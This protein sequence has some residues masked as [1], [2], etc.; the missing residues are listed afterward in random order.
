M[1]KG[2][3][4]AGELLRGLAL[5]DQKFSIVGADTMLSS[6][7]VRFTFLAT[8]HHFHG[9]IAA[10]L[11]AAQSDLQP[12]L[13]CL[14][15]LR[16][17]LSAAI[18]LEMKR[19][20]TAF[21]KQLSRVMTIK[22]SGGG[23]EGGEGEEGK[24]RSEVWY[25][26]MELAC[27]RG[28]AEIAVQQVHLL[29]IDLRA[30]MHDSKKRRE[31]K[32]VACRIQ[33]G[34]SL[35]DDANR[36]F[37]REG[38]L[39]KYS[40]YKLKARYRFFLFNDKLV[41]SH[42]SQSGMYKIHNE[43]LLSMMRVADVESKK[44]LKF[45]LIHPQKTFIVGCPNAALKRSWMEDIGMSVDECVERKLRMEEVRLEGRDSPGKG[46]GGE[47]N[48]D[49]SEI[50]VLEKGIEVDEEG[51]GVEVSGVEIQIG[52]LEEGEGEG[53]EEESLDSLFHRALVFSTDLLSDT[54]DKGHASGLKLELYSLFKQ[55]KEGDCGS[56]KDGAALDELGAMKMNAW[57]KRRGVGKQDA[58]S[59]Y[60][61]LLN[62]ISPDWASRTMR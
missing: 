61:E 23:G 56:E 16:Y 31:L 42:Q 44:G 5:F 12:V 54:G 4:G 7:L 20:R 10:T 21:A 32:A 18:F 53:G 2:V 8:W 48:G 45:E 15:V 50:S 41:Y 58:K 55:A 3:K 27:D 43:L 57:R 22:D 25:R 19:E 34:N 14:D 51:H 26:E 13:Y 29:I 52:D 33:G 59:M 39:V 40:R 6:D 49:W 38:D 17:A 11:D 60:V 28:E 1:Q 24:F 9:I 35:L 47:G 37:V 46:S 62:T 36:V 30:S